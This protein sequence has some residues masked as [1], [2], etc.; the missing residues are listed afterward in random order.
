MNDEKALQILA[1]MQ[2]EFTAKGRDHALISEAI[3]HVQKR[4]A[5][6]AAAGPIDA[7]D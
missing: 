7:K 6:T 2:S 1:E 3:A 5:E 4:L